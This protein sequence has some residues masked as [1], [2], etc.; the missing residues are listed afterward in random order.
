MH[1]AAAQENIKQDKGKPITGRMVLGCLV[2][3]FA[4]VTSV[5]AVMVMLAV[6]TFG[7]AETDSSYKAGLVFAREIA[8]A[9]AQ[10]ARQ[11]KVEAQILAQGSRMLVDV[12]SRDAANRALT[13]LEATV[14][15]S[16]PSDRRLDQRAAMQET[17]AGRFQGY[18]DPIAGQWDLVIELARDGDRL[19]RSKS[20]VAL[21]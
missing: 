6:S 2:A 12:T 1:A 3:F 18:I 8:A 20:R 15:L 14:H 9:Q 19:F 13:G 16:H 7:G 5:N 17:E 11:W 10:Q 21:H 4:T